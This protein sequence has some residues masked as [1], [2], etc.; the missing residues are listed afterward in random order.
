MKISS[1]HLDMLCAHIKFREKTTFYGLCKKDKKMSRKHHFLTPYFML[2]T[3]ATKHV[4][5]TWNNFVMT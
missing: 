4:D 3:H 2:F 1:V 5:F